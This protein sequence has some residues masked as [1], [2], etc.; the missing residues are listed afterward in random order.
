MQQKKTKANLLKALL[1]FAYF[2]FIK[3][4]PVKY[5]STAFAANFPS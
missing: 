1:S 5:L 3:L 2:Y 4:T